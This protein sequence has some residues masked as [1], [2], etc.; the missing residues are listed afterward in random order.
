MAVVG[1]VFIVLPHLCMCGGIELVTAL[2]PLCKEEYLSWNGILEMISVW[3]VV[4]CRENTPDHQCH[5]EQKKNKKFP[6][7]WYTPKYCKLNKKFFSKPLGCRIE[8]KQ[9]AEKLRAR[10]AERIGR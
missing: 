7:L 3:T 10:G 6:E 8:P 5:T 9:Q 2:A 4:C 1:T